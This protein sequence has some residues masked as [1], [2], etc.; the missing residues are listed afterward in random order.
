MGRGGREPPRLLHAAQNFSRGRWRRGARGGGDSVTDSETHIR[1]TGRR[2]ERERERE[3]ERK[4]NKK[5]KEKRALSSPVTSKTD[6]DLPSDGSSIS[7]VINATPG[8][9]REGGGGVTT[10]PR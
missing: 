4:K 7:R 1:C 6:T 10:A 9:R 3:R 8:R 5:R 2:E